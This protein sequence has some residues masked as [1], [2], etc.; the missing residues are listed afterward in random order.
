MKAFRIICLMM[1]KY[2]MICML[3]E[4]IYFYRP[5]IRVIIVQARLG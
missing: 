2:R 3:I 1:L 5:V 4:M